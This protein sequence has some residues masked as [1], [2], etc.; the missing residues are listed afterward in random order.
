MMQDIWL[1][2]KNNYPL[3]Y[4]GLW[5]LLM[6][7]FCI[8]MMQIDSRQL[9][10]VSTWLKPAKFAISTV[11]FLWSIAWLL[12]YFENYP[13]KVQFYSWAFSLLFLIEIGA[14]FLQAT[15]AVKSHY[16]TT[17]AFNAFVFG[18]MAITVA[19]IVLMIL[20]LLIDTFISKQLTFK[21][22]MLLAVRFGLIFLLIGSWVGSYMIGLQQHTVGVEAGK[23]GLFFLNWST[24][25]GDLRIAHFIGVH[26]LQILVIAV[27]IFRNINLLENQSV[28]LIILSS[29]LIF[30]FM[31]YT[32]MQAIM[33]IPLIKV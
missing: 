4:A 16:N 29:V 10:G 15:R 26:A 8:V 31:G 11:I 23:S 6:F 30:T 20:V 9:L 17:T 12:Q 18:V 14:I 13:Q 24:I 32:F 7:L 5:H 3:F 28:N 25:A 1:P 21:K 22:D 2:I 19:C 27:F 33:G